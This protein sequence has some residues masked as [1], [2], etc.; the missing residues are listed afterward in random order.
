MENLIKKLGLAAGTA[1]EAAIQAVEA[2][3][4]KLATAEASLATAT[5][6]L[7]PV[8][9][10]VQALETENAARLVTNRELT[11]AQIEND[12]TRY[13]NRFPASSRDAWKGL[14]VT[15][16]KTAI[17]LLEGLPVPQ[18]STTTQSTTQVVLNRSGAQTPPAAQGL[19]AAIDSEVIASK[20]TR[21]QAFDIVKNRDPGL[22]IAWQDAGCGPL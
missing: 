16:R 13:G 5:A 20:C 18:T 14:L 3:H 10:R 11:E 4:T 22:Y 9:N 8:K 6:A 15:N 12:L 7:E 21:G 19:K 1:E 17:A 2:L